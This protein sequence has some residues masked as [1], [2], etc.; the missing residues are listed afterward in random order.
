MTEGR[1]SDVTAVANARVH[2]TVH[3]RTSP[4][5]GECTVHDEDQGVSVIQPGPSC[6]STVNRFVGRVSRPA[7]WPAQGRAGGTA[8]LIE[9]I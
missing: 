5:K 2:R 6:W 3:P 1:A 4:C 8:S 9:G 7:A